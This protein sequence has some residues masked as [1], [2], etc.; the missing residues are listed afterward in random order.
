PTP[1]PVC[2]RRYK[3]LSIRTRRSVRSGLLTVHGCEV[4]FRTRLI[5]RRGK[6]N[7]M[8]TK[9]YQKGVYDRVTSGDASGRL[10]RAF[11]PEKEIH[12]RPQQYRDR[13]PAP[14]EPITAEEG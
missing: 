14:G 3:S 5:V 12:N 9:G 10:M 6:Q 8:V 7:R 2:R 1:G 11:D 13:S 4:V